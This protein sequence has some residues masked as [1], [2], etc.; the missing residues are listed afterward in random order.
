MP[1]VGNCVPKSGSGPGQNVYANNIYLFGQGVSFDKTVHISTFS[2]LVHSGAEAKWLYWIPVIYKYSEPLEEMKLVYSSTEKIY[3]S[4]PAEEQAEISGT[5]DVNLAPGTYIFGFTC[6]S[7]CAATI[8]LRDG[9]NAA[10]NTKI[11]ILHKSISNCLEP[12]EKFGSHSSTSLYYWFFCIDYSSIDLTKMEVSSNVQSSPFRISNPDLYGLEE[13]YLTDFAESFPTG[14]T[15]TLEASENFTPYE[16]EKIGPSSV[17]VTNHSYA[18]RWQDKV[19]YANGNYWVF[20]AE[21]DNKMYYKS[22]TDG[23][24]WS[25]KRAIRNTNYRYGETAGVFYDGTYFHIHVKDGWDLWLAIFRPESAGTLTMLSP[26]WQKMHYAACNQEWPGVVT[27]HSYAFSHEGGAMNVWH[28]TTSPYIYNLRPRFRYDPHD[29]TQDFQWTSGECYPGTIDPYDF[30]GN[31]VLALPEGKFL[32]LMVKLNETIK[33]YLWDGS[34]ASQET[35]TKTGTVCQYPDGGENWAYSAVVD[36]EGNVHL[37]YLNSSYQ[38]RYR[39]RL[40]N[41][42]KW[43][44][45]KILFSGSRKDHDPRI[46]LDPVTKDLYVFIAHAPTTNH[47]G[48]IKYYAEKKS[49]LPMID[50]IDESETGLST[51]SHSDDWGGL[52][53]AD[54]KVRDNRLSLI[55][56]I[57]SEGK[58]KLKFLCLKL[59]KW[60]WKFQK[61]DNGSTDPERTIVLTGSTFSMDYMVELLLNEELKSSRILRGYWAKKVVKP[62]GTP[63]KEP[64]KATFETSHF[65]DKVLRFQALKEVQERISLLSQ[66]IPWK[67]IIKK[68]LA[69]TLLKH[70]YI[71]I[72][73]KYLKEIR[74][75]D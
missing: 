1:T 10:P 14:N 41:L 60:R 26:S 59:P 68:Y 36:E 27:D 69:N 17:A 45:E 56:T 75:V 3:S 48:L 8:Y 30:R 2:F 20:W 12:P 33:A 16:F 42:G 55:W 34:W 23:I 28:Y 51:R 31:L 47:I 22:S 15:F 72:L 29:L 19:F 40:Y 9:E 24:N 4:W 73:L 53:N 52:I 44:E 18:I 58:H 13:Y 64:F 71:K 25:E 74:E 62:R 21:D 35:A 57:N 11:R 61:W 43:T 6:C 38:V 70:Y 50:L 54:R 49:W 5:L 39:K 63:I 46:V 7:K 32:V 67:A 65:L 66:V 37:V